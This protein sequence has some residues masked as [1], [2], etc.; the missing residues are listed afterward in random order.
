MYTDGKDRFMAVMEHQIKDKIILFF[1]DMN[2]PVL[3]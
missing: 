3:L 2:G 1:L